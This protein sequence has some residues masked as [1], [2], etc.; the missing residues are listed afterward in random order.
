MAELHSNPPFFDSDPIT[1]AGSAKRMERAVKNISARVKWRWNFLIR[2][3][4]VV[5]FLMYTKILS[6]IYS[7]MKQAMPVSPDADENR[8]HEHVVAVVH[9]F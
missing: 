4:I 1:T 3:V 8:T 5:V 9:P 7:S 2:G 6:N